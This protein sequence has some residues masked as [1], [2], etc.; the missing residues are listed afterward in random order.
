MVKT[1]VFDPLA[2]LAEQLRCNGVP[3]AWIK[4]RDPM[5]QTEPD[6]IRSDIWRPLFGKPVAVDR[7]YYA[8]IFD[9]KMEDGRRFYA[10]VGLHLRKRESMCALG[11]GLTHE[12]DHWEQQRDLI[13]LITES[14]N[15]LPNEPIEQRADTS[16]LS[17]DQ[18]KDGVSDTAAKTEE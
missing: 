17:R 9:W 2:N 13:R 3:V 12:A 1:I 15:T 14:A 18:L 5:T 16:E 4:M 11:F 10:K 6:E 7:D 8:P